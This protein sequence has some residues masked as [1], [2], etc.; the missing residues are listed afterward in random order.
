MVT[1]RSSTSEF[2]GVFTTGRRFIDAPGTMG[3]LT[4]AHAGTAG[5][6]GGR[7]GDYFGVQTDPDGL[8]FWGVGEYCDSPGLWKTWVT[9]WRVA[10]YW[11][12]AVRAEGDI[13]INVTNV[14]IVMT[15]DGRGNGNGNTPFTRTYYGGTAVTL[16]APSRVRNWGFRQW[17]INGVLQPLHQRSVTVNLNAET[18]AVAVFNAVSPG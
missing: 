5:Y 16:E 7:W 8:T 18:Q 4:L 11:N 10:T 13:A 9:S 14:P 15:T 6:T 2:A 12:V 1:G 3:S 17:R